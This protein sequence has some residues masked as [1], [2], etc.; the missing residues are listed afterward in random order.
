MRL[1]YTEKGGSGGGLKLL[2]GP[3]KP[4][5]LQERGQIKSGT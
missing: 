5:R 4:G 2:A 1:S 3:T